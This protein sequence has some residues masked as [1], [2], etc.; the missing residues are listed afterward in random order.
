[1]ALRSIEATAALRVA[2]L[3]SRAQSNRCA[4]T[5]ATVT[6]R[7]CPHSPQRSRIH[8]C[9]ASAPSQ[10]TGTTKSLRQHEH[11]WSPADRAGWDRTRRR[12][13]LRNK[14]SIVAAP[15]SQP[16]VWSGNEARMCFA[17]VFAPDLRRLAGGASRTARLPPCAGRRRAHGR[18]AR[19]ADAALAAGVG[20]AGLARSPL[21]RSAPAR[22][23]PLARAGAP[24]R[25]GDGADAPL[26]G[27]SHCH[28]DARR[29]AG[30]HPW[31]TTQMG[32]LS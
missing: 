23:R 16:A 13:R 30:V 9:V 12:R 32:A 20:I 11:T 21:P 22:L 25:A 31:K 5:S 8:Q 10:S 28:L 15:R 29:L 1:M 14:K 7:T 3:A 19:G 18:G 6:S 24:G 17:G 27:P 26:R 4:T 2:I